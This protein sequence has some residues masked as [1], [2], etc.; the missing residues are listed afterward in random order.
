M[1]KGLFIATYI[2]LLC[3]SSFGQKKFQIDLQLKNITGNKAYLCYLSGSKILIKDSSV[4]NSTGQATFS[5]NEI[6]GNGIY[7]MAVNGQKILEFLIDRNQYFQISYDHKSTIISFKQSPENDLFLS[8]NNEMK[9]LGREMD[10]LKKIQESTPSRKEELNKLINQTGNDIGQ[11]RVKLIQNQKG[12]LVSK[13]I[14]IMTPP[15][16]PDS[17][18]KDKYLNY[19]Y[20]K[21]HFWDGVDFG[22]DMVTRTPFFEGMLNTFFDDLVEADYK[23]ITAEMGIILKPASTNKTMEQFLLNYFINKYYPSEK[24]EE[25]KVFMWLFYTYMLNKSPVW[26]SSANYT[27]LKSKFEQLNSGTTKVEKKYYSN[28]KLRSDKNIPLIGEGYYKWFDEKGRPLGSEMYLH[29]EKH[30]K[31]IYYFRDEWYDMTLGDKIDRESV[32]ENGKEVS[33]TKYGTDG[34]I[35]SITRGNEKKYFRFGLEY[36]IEDRNFF[37]GDLEISFHKQNTQLVFKKSIEEINLLK[38]KTAG[39]VPFADDEGIV[40]STTTKDAHYITYIKWKDINNTEIKDGHLTFTTDMKVMNYHP[41]GDKSPFYEFK[42]KKYGQYSKGGTKEN[43]GFIDGDTY[44]LSRLYV[45]VNTIVEIKK[46]Q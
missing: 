35:M 21:D 22:D 23:A 34:K 45:L 5:G 39:E 46:Q 40:L 8:Y 24:E 43:F 41:G 16:V 9:R 29:N 37:T 3:S 6:L 30:G 44:F 32:Y 31:S 11:Y 13:L 36:K 15:V 18:K 17:L 12:S 33:E 1:R 2:V 19:K 25:K 7:C 20:Y 26:L 42:G 38:N 28:N 27:M 4:I 14:D 10:S